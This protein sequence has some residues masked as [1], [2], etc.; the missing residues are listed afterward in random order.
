MFKYV[1]FFGVIYFIYVYITRGSPELKK[2]YKAVVG[3]YGE[4]EVS[5]DLA[6]LGIPHVMNVYVPH[7]Y[8]YTE[9]DLVAVLPSGIYAIEVKNWGATIYGDAKADKWI[10]YYRNG[11][12]FTAYNPVKQNA[13]HVERLKKHF[14]K[15]CVKSVVVFSD[16]AN[17]KN[18]KADVYNYSVFLKNTP[19][20]FKGKQVLKESEIKGILYE[21]Q[22][23]AD[24]DQEFKEAHI[25]KVK[26]IRSKN[27]K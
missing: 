19:K 13:K 21:L 27:K 23:L 12:S 2:D 1:F 6:K 10:S 18:V 17:L 15:K 3:T 9:I 26:R 5:S 16:R 25:R 4:M 14:K 24:R 22:K 8:G 11:K 7:K 20:V